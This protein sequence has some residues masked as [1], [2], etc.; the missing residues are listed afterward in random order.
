MIIESRD[1]TNRKIAMAWCVSILTGLMLVSSASAAAE[2][3]PR[4]VDRTLKVVTAGQSQAV[5]VYPSVN[6]GKALADQVREAIR[7]TT[8][9]DPKLAADTDLVARVPEWPGEAYRGVPLILI[10]NINTN[11]AIVPLYANLLEGADVSYPGGDG[12]TLRT[13]VNPYGT[14]VNQLVLGASSIKGMNRA[15]KAFASL[16]QKHGAPGELTLPGLLEIQLEGEAAKA[17]ALAV[18]ATPSDRLYAT[19]LNYQWTGSPEVLNKVLTT[20]RAKPYMQPEGKHLGTA[21]YAT[22]STARELISLINAGV[23]SNEEVHHIE[24]MMLAELHREEKAF[25]WTT[26]RPDWVGTRHQSMGLSGTLVLADHLLNH[27]KPNDE[28]ADYLKKRLEQ[29]HAY[30]KQFEDRYRD[31]GNDNTSIDSNGPIL[32]YFMAFGNSKIF[33]SG[34]AAKMAQRSVMMTD[35][36][37]HFVGPGNYEDSRPGAMS[38]TLLRYPHYSIGVTAFVAGDSGLNWLMKNGSL[39][40]LSGRAW[41][42]NAG[43]AGERYPLPDDLEARQPDQWLGASVLHLTPY[44]YRLSGIYFTHGA[45]VRDKQSWESLVPQDKALDMLSFRDGFAPGNPYLFIIGAQGGRYSSMDA[46]SIVRYADRG[47]LWLIAQ[48]EQ[49]GHYFHNALHIGRKH[50]GNYFSTPGAIRLDALANFDD[51]TMTAT[52]LPSF[53]GADWTRQ[54]LWLRGKYFVV[55]DTASFNEDGDYDLTCTWRSLP[56]AELDADGVWRAE[57]ADARFELH[58]ADGLEQQSIHERG[59]STEQIAVDPYVLRQHQ[60][61][62]ARRGEHASIKNMFFTMPREAGKGFGLRKAG[63]D[64]VMVSDGDHFALIGANLGSDRTQIGRFAT[65]ARMFVASTDSV[66]LT[67]ETAHLWLDGQMVSPGSPSPE[68]SQALK[69]IW[70]GLEESKPAAA[71]EASKEAP[72]AQPLWSYDGFQ[73]LQQEIAGVRIV[74]P[75]EV[76]DPDLLFDRQALNHVPPQSWPSGAESVTYDLGQVE[77]I[78][79]IQLERL[80]DY[81]YVSSS[82][83]ER[84]PFW[85]QEK[86]GSML[87]AFSNDA[88]HSDVRQMEVSFDLIYRQD[89]PYHYKWTYMPSYWKQLPSQSASP[90]DVKARY[91]RTP[92][93]KTFETAFFRKAQ[94]PADVDRMCAVDLDGDGRDEL[95]IAT[96]ARQ[97]VVLN[98]DGQARWSKTLENTITDLY[99][100]D[101]D[102]DGKQSLLVS[103]NG[104]YIHGFDAQGR[105]VYNAD[106]KKEGIGG[107]FALGSVTPEGADKPFIVVGSTRGATVLDPEGKR[108]S[109]VLYGLSVSD[110]VLRGTSSHPLAAIRTATRNPWQIAGWKQM[111]WFPPEDRDKPVETKMPGGSMDGPWWLGLGMEFWPEDQAPDD[112]WRDGLAV[113]VARAGVYA[114][115]LGS[116]KTARSPLWKVIAN[117]PI[118]GYAW[119]DM[120]GQPGL[121][122]VVCR[123]DGFVDVL[124]RGGNVIGSWPVGAA[125]HGVSRWDKGGAVIAVAVGDA[126]VFYDA[127]GKELSRVAA[128]AEKILSLRDGQ[129]R[130]LITAAP[131][132]TAAFR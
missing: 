41:G 66:R 90:L 69:S 2:M 6:E 111:E 72:A 126:V 56:I 23:L 53:N 55:I 77:E 117:G 26:V 57:V 16:V 76:K 32:R 114:Y 124:D 29:A 52:T 21:D 50:D 58:N 1:A 17:A 93:G 60:A 62:K 9:A 15:V 67:P 118:S 125:A 132:R 54:V 37:G 95:A 102:G 107:A 130:V 87:L 121:E 5:I 99:A 88:F 22:E 94:R 108:Y 116:E 18:K 44:H 131:G 28:A 89:V 129:E 68:V 65:D 34:T 123:R 105:E 63:P 119:A 96:E 97:L 36:E 59:E 46:N 84:Q 40:P 101:L 122:L 38:D 48:T 75:A 14:G 78:G 51:V 20:L 86:A 8:G 81:K 85:M 24:T 42:I 39:K 64:A 110:L 45:E 27:A 92:A 113:V 49:F 83:P 7:T 120:N 100:V 47:H 70:S 30:F 61:L 73:R 10:G 33:Q 79:Q 98:P 11:R 74:E 43:I 19:A 128:P 91:V 4:Q 35:N 12:Y 127:E 25:P 80:L 3:L 106:T 104:W 13:I 115:D 103:D 31:E 82:L 71:T 109:A 112:T